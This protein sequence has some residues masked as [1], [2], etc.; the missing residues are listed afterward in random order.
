MFGKNIYQ[1]DV[2]N[3]PEI[4]EDYFEIKDEKTINEL[5]NLYNSSKILIPVN[6]SVSNE[7]REKQL[8]LLSLFDLLDNQLKSNQCKPDIYEHNEIDCSINTPYQNFDY[9]NLSNIDYDQ[10]EAQKEA[11]KFLTNNKN[12]LQEKFEKMQIETKHNNK[13]IQHEKLTKKMELLSFQDQEY[14]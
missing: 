7:F 3:F 2:P 11:A 10:N 1:D 12:E 14:E 5:M 4:S 8:G 9:Y 13:Q 6:G